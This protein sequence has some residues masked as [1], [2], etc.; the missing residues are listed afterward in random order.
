VKTTSCVVWPRVQFAVSF[1]IEQGVYLA[2]CSTEFG[3][4][5]IG[6]VLMCLMF[7]QMYAVR[8]LIQHCV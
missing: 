1:I 7:V 8:N 3:S 5:W 4:E 6:A 2:D